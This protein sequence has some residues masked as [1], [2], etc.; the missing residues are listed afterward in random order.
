SFFPPASN[1]GDNVTAYLVSWDVSETFNSLA[2]SPHSGDARVNSTEQAYTVQYLSTSRRY[3]VKVAAENSAGT[4]IA[5]VATPPSSYPSQQ[6]PGMPVGLSLGNDTTSQ[7]TATWDFPIIPANGIPCYG[8]LASPTMCPTPVG[9]EYA[10]S[11]GG[12]DI[13]EYRIQWSTDSR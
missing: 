1:G 4:G 10:G 5:R 7:V 13:Y 8:T 12:D 9:G 11:D 3:Y 6:V 2:G